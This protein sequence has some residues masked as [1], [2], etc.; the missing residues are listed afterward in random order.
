MW[1]YLS[2]FWNSITSVGGYAVEWFQSIGNAVAGSLGG[3]F[4]WLLHYL[5]DG[6]TFLH[7]ILNSFSQ[8]FSF[9]TSPLSYFYQFLKAFWLN[10]IKPPVE[11]SSVFTQYA[12]STNAVFQTIPYWNTLTLILGVGVLIL[13]AGAI[14]ALFLKLH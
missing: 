12:T 4:D 13:G 6:F 2:E 9:L 10:L 5:W 8:L 11:I 1:G 14:I 3:A 7:W